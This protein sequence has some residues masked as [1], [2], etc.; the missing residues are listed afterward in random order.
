MIPHF[1]RRRSVIC[2]RKSAQKRNVKSL[3]MLRFCYNSIYKHII[4]NRH[5]LACRAK[6]TM[7]TKSTS[8]LS[9][10]NPALAH[11]PPT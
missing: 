10:N 5:A 9:R 1:L 8:F 7:N 2:P 11:T 4:E 6:S 3:N